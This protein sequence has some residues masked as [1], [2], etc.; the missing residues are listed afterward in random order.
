LR[1]FAAVSVSRGSAGRPAFR[2]RGAGVGLYGQIRATEK[3]I[4]PRALAPVLAMIDRARSSALCGISIRFA[5]FA[6]ARRRRVVPK[7]PVRCFRD[8]SILRAGGR[9]RGRGDRHAA[10]QAPVLCQARNCRSPGTAL[11]P[12]QPRPSGPAARQNRPQA[13]LPLPPSPAQLTVSLRSA[14]EA[15]ERLL[16][17][18]PR[19]TVRVVP[20]STDHAAKA[21]PAPAPAPPGRSS[22]TTSAPPINGR[23]TR[24]AVLMSSVNPGQVASRSAWPSGCRC[25][26]RSARRRRS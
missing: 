16:Q 19:S 21:T 8:H 25:G 17:P 14:N 26:S 23:A 1:P 20:A 9:V 2:P 10:S 4:W 15:P 13:P 7:A 5:P 12:G 24:A 18:S 6:L 3:Q 22:P 11:Q